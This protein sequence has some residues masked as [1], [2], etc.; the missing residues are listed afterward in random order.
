MPHLL[1]ESH[2]HVRTHDV[3]EARALVTRTHRP[4][5]IE[6]SAAGRGFTWWAN[7]CSVGPVALAAGWFETAT[8]ITST[9]GNSFLLSLARRGTG[10]FLIGG[11]VLPVSPTQGVFQSPDMGARYVT[12][13]DF[14]TLTVGFDRQALEA[15]LR[16]LLGIQ[17]GKPLQLE[18]RFGGTTGGGA[19]IMRLLSFMVSELDRPSSVNASRFVLAHLQ[20][21]LTTALLLGQPHTYSHLLQRPPPDPSS[22]CVREVEAY[23]DAHIH[24]PITMADLGRAAGVSVRSIHY[25]FQKHRDYSPTEFI[26]SRRIE[27]ARRRL[28][29]AQPGFT[30][31]DIATECGFQH[32]GRFSCDYQKTFGE[33]PSATL[34][35]A[36][37]KSPATTS[38]SR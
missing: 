34:R 15:E 9:E 28:L 2:P 24:E 17:V 11:E 20:N 5:A 4:S 27:L 23:I 22:A 14:E 7:R 1:F 12:G 32:L 37:G 38:R 35:R 33:S 31:T 29:S 13:D 36:V 8:T 26:R 18:A 16:A 6:P 30:V 19:D 10:H 3:D 25:A 21:A